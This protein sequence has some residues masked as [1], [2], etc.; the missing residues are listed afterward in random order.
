[1]CTQLYQ[2]VYI[3]THM[4]TYMYLCMNHVAYCMC[5]HVVMERYKAISLYV[6]ICAH[7]TYAYMYMSVTQISMHI[8]FFFCVLACIQ[9]II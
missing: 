7:S 6:D 5:I 4:H 1:M 8:M 3:Y 2:C 9:Y